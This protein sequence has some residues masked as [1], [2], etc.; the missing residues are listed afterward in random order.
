MT[1][2][3]NSEI[4]VTRE[5]T[6]EEFVRRVYEKIK[7]AAGEDYAES[8]TEIVASMSWDK[9]PLEDFNEEDQY[10]IGVIAMLIDM[11]YE[12]PDEF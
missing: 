6:R 2:T 8:H 10:H 7:Y 4:T 12:I 11:A 1:H 3:T 9:K 5:V